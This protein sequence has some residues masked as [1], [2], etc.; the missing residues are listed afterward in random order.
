MVHIVKIID[1]A[2]AKG[3]RPARF[4]F[5]LQPNF[6]DFR[7]IV[8]IGFYHHT[9]SILRYSLK[10]Y[11][12]PA[13]VYLAGGNIVN[14]DRLSCAFV[15]FGLDF[16]AVEMIFPTVFTAGLVTRFEFLPHEV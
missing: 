7:V 16:V 2:F 14:E 5:R 3:I 9:R 4:V 12:V 11:L 8:Q 1:I 13:A 6:F 15:V 10:K